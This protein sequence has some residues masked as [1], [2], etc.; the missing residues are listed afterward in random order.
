MGGGAVEGRMV[1]SATGA[2]SPPAGCRQREDLGSCPEL[3]HLQAGTL[4][5]SL[6]PQFSY[7]E[8]GLIMT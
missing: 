6:N 5:H 3:S 7:L 2:S 4:A 1:T 8:N